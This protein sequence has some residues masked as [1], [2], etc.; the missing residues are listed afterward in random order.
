MLA[1]KRKKTTVGSRLPIQTRST[2][3]KLKHRMKYFYLV[4][5]TCQTNSTHEGT[6]HSLTSRRDQMLVPAT[7]FFN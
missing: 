6:K 5:R 1:Q 4:A 3:I 7:T 2:G